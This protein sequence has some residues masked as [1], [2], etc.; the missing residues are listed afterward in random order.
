MDTANFGLGGV[1][2]LMREGREIDSLWEK[3]V[4]RLGRRWSL[5][6]GWS[7][8]FFELGLNLLAITIIR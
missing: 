2:G 7:L 4:E 8:G 5:D 3:I 1:V 6:F